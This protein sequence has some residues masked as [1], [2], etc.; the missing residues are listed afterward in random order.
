MSSEAPRLVLCA[1]TGSHAPERRRLHS[2]GFALFTRLSSVLLALGALR[3]MRSD[4]LLQGLAHL[5]LALLLV[6]LAWFR[7]K[8]IFATQEGL[9]LGSGKRKRLVPWSRVLDIRELPWIRFSPPWYPKMWQVDLDNERFDFCGVRN[10]RQI[11]IEFVAR[12][13]AQQ[14]RD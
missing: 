5:T 3:L 12:A 6:A 9:A 4:T 2:L 1:L 8:P 14:S 7:P 13:E 10:A 11:V